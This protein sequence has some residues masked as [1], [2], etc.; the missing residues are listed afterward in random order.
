MTQIELARLQGEIER[1]LLTASQMQLEFVVY[2][3]TMAKLELDNELGDQRLQ[4]LAELKGVVS[5]Q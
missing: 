4:S 5:L 2:I 3:L 1:A